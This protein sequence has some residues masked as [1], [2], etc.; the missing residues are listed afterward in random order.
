MAFIIFRKRRKEFT[1]FFPENYIIGQTKKIITKNMIYFFHFLPGRSP[2]P[3]ET[4]QNSRTF[5]SLSNNQ[6]LIFP[7]KCSSHKLRICK[8]LPV[9]LSPLVKYSTVDL[10]TEC[11]NSRI[12][13]HLP[14]RTYVINYS[15]EKDTLI[16]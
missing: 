6:T 3:F 13:Y 8:L 4:I 2:V 1:I 11:V 12:P 7:P 10:L 16:F 14:K 15:N 5:Y 9:P